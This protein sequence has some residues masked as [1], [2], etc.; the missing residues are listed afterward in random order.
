VNSRSVRLKFPYIQNFV[1]VWNIGPYLMH[2]EFK[3]FK[4]TLL[5]SFLSF[6]V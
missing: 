3:T 1:F 2:N 5:V 4:C 6:I